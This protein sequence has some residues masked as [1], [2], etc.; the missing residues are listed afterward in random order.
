MSKLNPVESIAADRFSSQHC[1]SSVLLTAAD[2][3]QENQNGKKASAY[4]L[5]ILFRYDPLPTRLSPALVPVDQ[6]PE[7]SLRCPS[8]PRK[9]PSEENRGLTVATKQAQ[10]VVQ[11]DLTLEVLTVSECS[12]SLLAE[13][14]EL[15]LQL[16]D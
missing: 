7:R 14:A 4:H 8:V 13:A 16:C 6:S 2:S 3:H 10:H 5:A 12:I 9:L 1:G 15:S 11:A